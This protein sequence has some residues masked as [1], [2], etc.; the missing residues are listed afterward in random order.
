[1]ME[2]LQV[3]WR[4]AFELPTPCAAWLQTADAS[5]PFAVALG[6]ALHPGLV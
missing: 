2:A 5:Q 1:L 6:L 4:Q 3:E